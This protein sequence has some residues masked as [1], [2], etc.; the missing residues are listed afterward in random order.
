MARDLTGVVLKEKWRIDAQLGEGGVAAVYAATHRNGKRVAVKVLHPHLASI[1]EVRDRFL[2]EGYLAN[3]VDHPGAVGVTDDDVT[4]DGLVFLVM[5]LLDGESLEKRLAREGRLPPK[6]VLAITDAL[7]DV[8]S[9]AH[10]KGII[11]RDIKPE[12]IYLCRDGGQKL[13]DFGI[14]RLHEQAAKNAT[15][16][17]AAMGTPSYMPPEQARG[18]W[19]LVDARSDLWAVGATMFALLTGRSVHEAE[20]VNETLLLAMAQPAPALASVWPEAPAPIAAIV[21]RALAF[22]MRDRWPDATSMR[23]AVQGARQRVSAQALAPRLPAPGAPPMTPPARTDATPAVP[24]GTV[25]AS[26][27]SDR[28]PHAPVGFLATTRGRLV[29]SI[30]VGGVVGVAFVLLLAFGRGRTDERPQATTA[31]AEPPAAST[32]AA[33]SSLPTAALAPEAPSGSASA[34][35]VIDVSQL[36]L[37]PTTHASAPPPVALRSAAPPPVTHP[38]PTRPTSSSTTPTSSLLDRRH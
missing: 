8:L 30:G 27:V 6:D 36:P 7:L 4:N 38:P 1:P 18:R 9:A 15:Q 12:N 33:G 19:E 31:S 35:A 13:L 2:R 29:L 16:T 32:V 3:R 20:T 28:P 24:R 10:A 26:S 14:A 23:Q 11:H 22:G 34:T 17:G 25:L 21:D 37:A 5:E